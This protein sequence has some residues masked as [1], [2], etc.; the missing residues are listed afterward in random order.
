[1]NQELIKNSRLLLR[2]ETNNG[3]LS[4]YLEKEKAAMRRKTVILPLFFLLLLASTLLAGCSSY[5][6]ISNAQNYYRQAQYTKAMSSLQQKAPSILKAQGPIILNY[7]LGLLARL[8]NEYET[9]NTLLSESERLIWEAYTQSITANIASFLVNDN[10]KAYPG[11]EYEDVYINIFKAL[12]YLHLGRSESALVELRRS[13]EK[14]ANLRQKYE[15]QVQKISSY[16]D[17]QGFASVETTRYATSFST[18]A[19]AQYLSAIVAQKMG[20]DNTFY[21]AINQARH[22]FAS[23]SGLYDFPMPSVFDIEDTPLK[24]SKARVHLISFTGQA[25]I[26]QERRESV[27]VSRNNYAQIAYPVLVERKSAIERV[28]VSIQGGPTQQLEKIESISNIAIDTFKAKSEVIRMKAVTRAM[29]KAVGIALYDAY[30][31][32]D[33]NVTVFEELLGLIFR[34]AQTVSESADVRSVHFLPSLSWVGYVD[35]EPGTY[36]FTYEFLNA[37]GRVVH[38]HKVSNLRVTANSVH[39]VEAHSPL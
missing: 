28:K 7:D 31:E 9:S 8:S 13:I 30:T 17:A 2:V 15:Q 36:T 19:L 27:W 10:T 14:Q 32:K 26:K 4:P 24:D 29:A 34:V 23:Q 25:P 18:S 16:S 12:N 6:D 11:E 21:Y 38:S 33:N 37:S 5:V 1:M 35:L 3:T 20:E 39:L 22:A